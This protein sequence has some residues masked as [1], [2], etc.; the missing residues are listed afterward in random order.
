MKKRIQIYNHLNEPY[1]EMLKIGANE[2]PLQRYKR[3]FLNRIKFRQ[4]MGIT[5]PVKRQI[6]IKKVEWI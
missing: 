4:I 1:L 6:I 2:T 5:E 3:F